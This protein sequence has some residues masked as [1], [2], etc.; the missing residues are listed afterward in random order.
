MSSITIALPDD[1]MQKLQKMA[2]RHQVAPE[3]L[4]RATVEDLVSAPTESFEEALEYVL[5]KNEELY[6]RLAR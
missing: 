6:K 2:E 1:L 5:A 4:V 3:E